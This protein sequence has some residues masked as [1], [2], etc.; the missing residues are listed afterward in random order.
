[1]KVVICDGIVNMYRAFALH[2][3]SSFVRKRIAGY[4]AVN[5]ANRSIRWVGHLDV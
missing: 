4:A 2:G 3:S 5:T 1:M